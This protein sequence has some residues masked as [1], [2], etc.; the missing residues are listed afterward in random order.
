MGRTRIG[1]LVLMIVVL[2]LFW[3]CKHDDALKPPKE[4]A[5]YRLPPND[6][7]F[8]EYPRFPDKEMN[9]FPKRDQSAEDP[10]NRMP[11]RFGMGGPG[12]PQ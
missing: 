2:V 5:E 7:R 6:P 8:S 1:A 12:G 10:M 3:G 9:K 4:V 11:S